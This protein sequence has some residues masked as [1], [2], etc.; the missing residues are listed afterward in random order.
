M[1]PG[2]LPE[3]RGCHRD[4]SHCSNN[5]LVG[6]VETT[7]D[8]VEPTFMGDHVQ[9]FWNFMGFRI[10]LIAKPFEMRG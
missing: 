4:M 9:P 7:R 3:E 8:Q 10:Q 6:E 5:I 1:R 2:V